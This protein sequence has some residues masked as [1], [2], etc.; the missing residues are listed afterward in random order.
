MRPSR[1]GLISVGRPGPGS[2]VTI[3]DKQDAEF[4]CKFCDQK[5]FKS[6]ATFMNHLS[7][8]H[9]SVEGGSYICRYFLSN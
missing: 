7:T 1:G 9:V 8:S 2:G 4:Q 6:S 3:S 5:K